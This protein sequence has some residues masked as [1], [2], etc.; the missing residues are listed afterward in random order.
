MKNISLYVLHLECFYFFTVKNILNHSPWLLTLE[1][2]L[3]D[4]FSIIARSSGKLAAAPI[5]G[6]KHMER[7]F[8]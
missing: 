8:K 5:S 6:D 1:R 7:I 2:G 3:S 4:E